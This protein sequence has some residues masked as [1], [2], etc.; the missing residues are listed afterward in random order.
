MSDHCCCCLLCCWYRQQE[1]CSPRWDLWAAEPH[2]VFQNQTV[3]FT[4]DDISD[5]H[6]QTLYLP[7]ETQGYLQ[8]FPPAGTSH[9]GLPQGKGPF[10]HLSIFPKPRTSVLTV[11]RQSKAS[12]QYQGAPWR[13]PRCRSCSCSWLEI[14]LSC[15]PT[16]VLLADLRPCSYPG[17][18]LSGCISEL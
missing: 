18:T 14:Q 13:A 10:L 9:L 11:L 7:T 4:V 3:G 15:H 12:A 5:P 6:S 16:S 1:D 17:G 8:T 2:C